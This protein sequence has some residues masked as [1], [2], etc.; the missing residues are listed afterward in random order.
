MTRRTKSASVLQEFLPKQAMNRARLEAVRQKIQ[1]VKIIMRLEAFAL[2]EKINVNGKL[3]KV[4]LSTDQIRTSFG[5]LN[6]IMP[7][8]TRVEHDGQ[9][10][11]NLS[12]SLAVAREAAAAIAAAQTPAAAAMTYEQLMLPAP[13]TH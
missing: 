13:Q 5:L 10:G 2:G 12:G 1:A 9:V 3:K 7:D 6:K 11:V 8:V 4:V